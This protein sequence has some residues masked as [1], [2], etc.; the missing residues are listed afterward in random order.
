[1]PQYA[2]LDVE[3]SGKCLNERGGGNGPDVDE[4]APDSPTLIPL[5]GKRLGQLLRGDQPIPDELVPKSDRTLN[6]RLCH[7]AAP[8]PSKQTSCKRL[9]EALD[10]VLSV[11]K[12]AEPPC[13]AGQLENLPAR[14]RQVH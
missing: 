11:L 13:E 14:R 8:V 4:R 10:G 5:S 9:Q 6:Q 7:F 3:S 2:T 12:E 1:M